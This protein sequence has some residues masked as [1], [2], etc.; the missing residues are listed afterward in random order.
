MNATHPTLIQPAN[1]QLPSHSSLFTPYSIFAYTLVIRC[2]SARLVRG[3]R[4]TLCVA[5]MAHNGGAYL[6]TSPSVINSRCSLPTSAHAC[7]MASTMRPTAS[8]QFFAPVKSSWVYMKLPFSLRDRAGSTGKA[9][10]AANI[11]SWPTTGAAASER[12]RERGNDKEF[13]RGIVMENLAGEAADGV[14]G[15][16]ARSRLFRME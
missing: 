3:P 9:L 12:M 7:R 1:R 8:L 6:T 15:G 16:V 11:V 10:N 14:A 2:A 13:L 4:L 5:H